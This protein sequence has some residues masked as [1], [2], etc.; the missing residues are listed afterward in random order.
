MSHQGK[1]TLNVTVSVVGVSVCVQEA[2]ASVKEMC[3]IRVELVAR[4]LF[5]QHQK[6]SGPIVSL[7]P[8]K[9]AMWQAREMC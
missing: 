7:V 2:C 1:Q 6:K 4:V 3:V 5:A 9:M 8:D